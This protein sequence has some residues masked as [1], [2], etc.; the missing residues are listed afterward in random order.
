MAPDAMNAR[1]WV[2]QA[3]IMGL[4]LLIFI[5]MK[6]LFIGVTLCIVAIIQSL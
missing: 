5:I 4:A 2:E 1:L 3:L 6:L